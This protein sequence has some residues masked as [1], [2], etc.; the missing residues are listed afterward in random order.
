M[1]ILS[2]FIPKELQSNTFVISLHAQFIA[3]GNLSP[4]QINSLKDILDIEE[5]FYDWEYKCENENSGDYSDL[6]DKLV[7][8]RF[9]SVKGRNKCIR[10]MQSIINGTPN[11]QLINEALGLVDY[12][13]RYR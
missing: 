4:R 3:R 5:D 1:K 8:N 6:K 10:A 7:K 9:R 12:R 11:Y 13:K 2:F